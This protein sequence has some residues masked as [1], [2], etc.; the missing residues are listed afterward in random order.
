MRSAYLNY[1]AAF[2]REVTS[3]EEWNERAEA[4]YENLLE[5][6]AHNVRWANGEVSYRMGVSRMTDMPRAEKKRLMTQQASMMQ[7]QAPFGAESLP[8]PP[9]ATATGS[10]GAFATAIDWRDNSSVNYV[11]PVKDQANCGGCW[12]FTA[13]AAIESKFKI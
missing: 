2:N 13:I 12:A 3:L 1:Q 8:A 9:R 5:I 7:Q 4:Y 11:S 6:S 10:R